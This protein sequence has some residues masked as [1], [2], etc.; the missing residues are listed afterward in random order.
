[1][2]LLLEATYRAEQHHFWFRGFRRFVAPLV[3]EAAAGRRDLRMLDCGC[4]TGANLALLEPHGRAVGLD[5]TLRGLQFA[6]QYGRRALI[7]ASATDLPFGDAGFDIVTSFDVIYSLTDEQE[8]AALREMHRVL[9]PGGALIVNVAALPILKGN[10]SVLSLER[11]RYTRSLLLARLEQAGFTVARITYT[12]ASLFPLLLA[13]RLA[14]RALGFA[15]D[16]TEATQEIAVPSAPVNAAL[17]ALLRLE[18]RLV[19]HVPMP[20][21]SSLLALARK[22]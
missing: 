20:F 10:H 7:Q 8:T 5:L 18:A 11:R 21:G 12:N 15:T 19:R 22:R 4:G 17:S 1:M 16:E 13:V 14:Q 2:D 3:D 6:R 9:R